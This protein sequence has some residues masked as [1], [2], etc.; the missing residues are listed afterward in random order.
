LDTKRTL[1]LAAAVALATGSIAAGCGD[2]DDS[3]SASETT[4]EM[5]ADASSVTVTADEYSFD[6]SAT[7]TADTKEVVF[8]NVGKKFHVMIFARINE[9]FTVEEAVELQGE[10]GSA[11]VVAQ[12]EAEPGTE[13]TAKVRGP[14]EPGEYAMLC[15]IEDKDGAHYELG[16]L[17][18]FSIG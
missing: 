1:R 5:T 10:K 12:T 14:L 4:T 15:P 13:K 8:D 9:G 17:E 7:P 18:E 3:D 2:D 11:E 16:Q 6:L